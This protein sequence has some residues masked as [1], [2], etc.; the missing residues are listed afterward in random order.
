MFVFISVKDIQNN[1]LIIF[2]KSFAGI[3]SIFTVAN[4]FIVIIFINRLKEINCECSEDIKREVY[5][6]YNIVLAAIIGLTILFMLVGLPL[7]LMTLR[8]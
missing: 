8:R 3:V 4:I 6:V 7:A 1:D 5:W 2:Y